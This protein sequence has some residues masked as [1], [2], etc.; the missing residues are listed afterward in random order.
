MKFLI[1]MYI[2][3][4]NSHENMSIDILFRSTGFLEKI[5]NL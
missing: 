3:N 5:A 1:K 2:E 4:Q